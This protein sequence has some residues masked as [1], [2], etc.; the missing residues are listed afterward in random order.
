L[1]PFVKELE[2]SQVELSIDTPPYSETVVIQP[3]AAAI[4]PQ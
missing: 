4:A 3:V 2:L 1:A